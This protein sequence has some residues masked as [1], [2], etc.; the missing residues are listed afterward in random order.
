MSPQKASRPAR[1]ASLVALAAL[2]VV[3]G[4]VAV[5]LAGR[6]EAPRPPAAEPPPEG[7]RV[8]LKEQVR[9]EEYREGRLVASVR[10]DTFFL[11]PDGRNHLRGAV[12]VVNY[13]P[14][15]DVRSRLT[16]D[17]I[18]YDKDA[19][20]F[21][22]T[23]RVRVEASGAVLEGGSFDHDKGKGIFGTKAGGAFSS[24]TMTGKAAEIV[25]SE[26][27]DELRLDGGFEVALLA[28]GR[29]GEPVVL[30]GRAFTYRRAE[31]RGRVEGRA[32]LAGGGCRGRSDGLSITAAEDEGSVGSAVFEGGA[33]V[34][35]SGPDESV[36]ERGSVEAEKVEVSFGGGL[37][38][39]AEADGAV[40][41]AVK[42]ARGPRV[43]VRAGNAKIDFDPDGSPGDWTVWGGFR[44]DP[45]EGSGRASVLEGESAAFDQ[46]A[47]LLRVAG[48]A[49]R[50]AVA[51]S[52]EARVEAPFL[53]VGPGEGDLE[54]SGGTVCL[55]KPAEKSRT[56][57]LFSPGQ[58]V[59]VTA[60]RLVFRGGAG[61]A[62]FSG[63]VR[64]SAD[65]D[66]VLAREIEISDV[67]GELRGAGGITA[68]LACPAS[69]GAPDGR[70]HL[71]GESVVFSSAGRTL[72]F[73]GR[74][75][76]R[77]GEA[78][79]EAA[80]VTAVLGGEAGTVGS[81]TA[82]TDVV[83]SRGKYEGRAG[84]ASFEAKT[85]R[86]VLTGRPVLTDEE[87][88][89]ARG[90]KLTFDLADDKILIENEGPGR[91]TTVV[92]S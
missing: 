83:L 74:S 29:P 38:A 47:A 87:G 6:R 9:H 31:R 53:T 14:S 4:L 43:R 51:D 37:I 26:S 60:E 22:L 75:T 86:I 18:V 27:A 46:A 80:T 92:R 69:R 1:L 5:R 50:P 66:S 25:Y 19:V 82:K 16:A 21:T 68:E 13:G 59:R 11:G 15:G 12:E 91:S 76:V 71:G 35:L 3:A 41:L 36:P 33:R 81:F 79:L 64:L 84:A 62:S 34:V 28:A 40:L 88:G 44:A 85:D 90:D 49:G 58:A 54:A 42:P 61:A 39:S 78:R 63:E 23:G 20:L 30:R 2:L 57:G 70:V 65:K 48:A 45:V 72:S 24:R 77:L 56:A 67:A 8:D 55:L 7:R 73:Q 89:S 10:G 52:P 17:E 32:E